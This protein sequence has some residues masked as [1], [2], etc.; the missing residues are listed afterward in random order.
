M[1]GSQNMLLTFISEASSRSSCLLIQS[2]TTCQYMQNMI[3]QSFHLWI[4]HPYHIPSCKVLEFLG[5]EDEKNKNY[6]LWKHSRKQF[7]WHDRA[8]INM[9]SQWLWQNPEEL[10]QAQAKVPAWPRVGTC[11]PTGSWEAIGWDSCSERQS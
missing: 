10:S 6:R 3:L 7:F 8:D 1:H 11:S 2:L 9:K 5:E 4:R